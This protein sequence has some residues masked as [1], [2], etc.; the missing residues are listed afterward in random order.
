M[1]ALESWITMLPLF[2]FR[3][4]W[5]GEAHKLP[6]YIFDPSHLIYSARGHRVDFIFLRLRVHKIS[7]LHNQQLWKENDAAV[8]KRGKREVELRED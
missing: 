5:N 3:S 6:A 2:L 8:A 1:G 4:A 7:G